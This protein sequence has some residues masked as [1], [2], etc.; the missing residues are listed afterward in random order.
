MFFRAADVFTPAVSLSQSVSHT[1]M[2][3]TCDVNVMSSMLRVCL[4]TG[5][6]F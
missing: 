5:D 4:L 3:F 1:D 6:R 2:R